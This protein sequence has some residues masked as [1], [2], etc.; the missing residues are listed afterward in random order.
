MDALARCLLAGEQAAAPTYDRASRMLGRRWRWL[1]RLV[2]RYLE[3]FSGGT[4]PRHRGVTAF[5]KADAGFAQARAKHGREISVAE[6]IEEPP[7][8]QPVEAAWPHLPQGA[9]TSPSLANLCARRVDC[10]LTGL[11]EAA[12]AVYTRYADDL[13]FSGGEEFEQRVERFSIHAAATLQEEGFAVHHRKTRIMPRSVRQHLAGLV[14]NRRVNVR[15]RDFDLLKAVL[16][17]C[18]RLGPEN[19]NRE[20]HEHF[21]SHLEGRVDS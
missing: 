5:L 21:R 17:N 18:A 13:A 20:A 14:T 9:P 4:R 7:Q 10:R 15:R 11:A 1:R 19:Q 2:L 6:R 12:G 3:A 8:M 16:T